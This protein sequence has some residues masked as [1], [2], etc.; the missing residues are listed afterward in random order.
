MKLALLICCSAMLLASCSKKDSG[1]PDTGS[2]TT[3]LTISDVSYSDDAKQKMDI[4]LPAGRTTE[5]TKTLVVIHGGGWTEGDKSD[6]AFGVDSFKKRFPDYA[7]I[8]INYRLEY[9]NTNLFPAQENDVKAAIEFYLGKS[10]EY[11]VSNDLV[12]LGASAGA[13]LA[14]LHSYKNDPGKHVKAVV[15]FFGPTDLKAL[16]S[17]GFVQQSIL[18]AVT[19]KTY[20]QDTSIYYQ[21]SPINFVT[22]QTPPT[23]VLQG[24]AD[25][26]VA[27]SQSTSLIARLDENGVINELAFYPSEEHGWVGANLTDSFEKI[28]AF[29]KAN[30]H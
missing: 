20:D 22:A 10:A 12:V 9:N 18:I 15:D 30:V 2:T 16:W 17:S 19:G 25:P 7:V 3:A 1:M 5:N 24:G 29:I 13:H 23:I 14:L 27:P 11:K 26:V 8:N 6:M 28:E 21:S 4:Y